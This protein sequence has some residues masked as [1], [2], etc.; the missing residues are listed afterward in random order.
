MEY[1]ELLIYLELDEPSEFIYFEAMADLV[2]SDEDIAQEAVLG[3]FS[4][5]DMPTVAGLFEEYFEDIMEG[6]PE[7]S[8]GIYSLLNQIKMCL[9]GL[10]SNAEDESDLRR[11]TDEFCRFRRWYSEESDVEMV[12]MDGGAPV[13]HCLR[14]AITCARMEKLGGDQYQYDFDY[15]LDYPLDSY[16]MSFAELVAAGEDDNEGRIEFDPKEWDDYALDN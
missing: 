12:P 1:N 2:E 13:H 5:A 6:L 3:L 14:D 15:A 11:L 10:A 8:G 4:G 9:T 7:E 16:T